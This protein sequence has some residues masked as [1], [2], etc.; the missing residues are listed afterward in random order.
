[1]AETTAWLISGEN[2]LRG[3]R[4]FQFTGSLGEE[5]VYPDRALGSLV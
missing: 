2:P 4:L 1:M 3:R 5:D